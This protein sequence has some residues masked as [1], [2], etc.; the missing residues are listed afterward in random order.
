MPNPL[1]GQRFKVDDRVTRKCSSVLQNRFSKKYGNVTETI[2]KTNAKGNTMYYYK[3]LWDDK[4]SSEH[5]QHS[6][7]PIKES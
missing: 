5:A 7:Q 2:E 4:R 6:L 1:V 3:V